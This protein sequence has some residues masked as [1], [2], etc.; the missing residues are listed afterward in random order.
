MILSAT[1]NTNIWFQNEIWDQLIIIVFKLLCNKRGLLYGFV[2]VTLSNLICN[3]IW[4]IL[5]A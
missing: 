2:G 1:T 3:L 5:A 4:A